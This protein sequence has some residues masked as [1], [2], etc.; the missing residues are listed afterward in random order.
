[1]KVLLITGASSGIGL[2]TAKLF[3]EQGYEVINISRRPCPLEKVTQLSCDLALPSALEALASPLKSRLENADKVVL[4][5]NAARLNNDSFGNTSADS[6]REVL[7][8]NV[9]AASTLNNIILP[10]LKPGSSV[11]YVGSTLAE[12]AVAGTFSYVIS[13]HAVIGMMR[14]TCQDLVG[15]GIHT[16]CICPG[17][18]DTEMLREHLPEDALSSIAEMNAFG[19]L[20]K[21]EEIA[22]SLWFAAENPVV[23]G[24]VIHA[25]L[26][27]IEN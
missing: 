27:Q 23:N 13:K 6:F 7:E 25:N 3:N 9:V 14:A 26:G 11:I 8:I 16:A 12:K 20:V 18:T 21:P 15:K 2:A 1:M 22:G 24:T 19:R 10:Y 17:F 5:H 4:I